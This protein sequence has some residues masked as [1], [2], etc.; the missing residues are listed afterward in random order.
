M[1]ESLKKHEEIHADVGY[2]DRDASFPAV[3]WFGVGLAVVT[4]LVQLV[5][6]WQFHYMTSLERKQNKAPF[7][8][9]YQPA[10]IPKTAPLEGL[11][12]GRSAA[13]EARARTPADAYGWVDRKAGIVRVPVE[14]AEALL[15]G[16]LPAR[17]E[18]P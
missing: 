6:W 16:R 13:E 12:P 8:A 7:T 14:R 11:V 10:Q 15:A 1:D 2:E 4:G 17:E 9:Q 3:V 18:K 5:V